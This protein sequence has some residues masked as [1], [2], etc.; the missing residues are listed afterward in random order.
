MNVQYRCDQCGKIFIKDRHSR[1]R[2]CDECLTKNRIESV[3]R[4]RGGSRFVGI[5]DNHEE[6]EKLKSGITIHISEDNAKILLEAVEE[7]KRIF[8]KLEDETYVK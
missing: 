2:T 3:A 5:V 8:K 4:Y 7:I 1:K 6:E